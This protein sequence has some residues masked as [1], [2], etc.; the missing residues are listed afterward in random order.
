[1]VV[2]LLKQYT[3]RLIQLCF[4]H[5]LILYSITE[6]YLFFQITLMQ[7]MT[8]IT[9]SEANWKVISEGKVFYKFDIWDLNFESKQHFTLFWRVAAKN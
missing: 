8:G 6:M 7:N 4:V 3:E 5:T 2:S 9:V 1:M